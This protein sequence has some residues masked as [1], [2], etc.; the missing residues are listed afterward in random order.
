MYQAPKYA[1]GVCRMHA[2][3]GFRPEGCGWSRLLSL[4]PTYPSSN[5]GPSLGLLGGIV[6]FAMRAVLSQV[7]LSGVALP[8]GQVTINAANSLMRQV[9]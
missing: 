2:V 4:G 3:L 5:T 1:A 7:L 6:R 9:S 8:S